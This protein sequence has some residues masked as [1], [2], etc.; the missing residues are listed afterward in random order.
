MREIK[1]RAWDKEAELF[2]IFTLADIR[3]LSE[4]DIIIGN[5]NGYTF[6][7]DAQTI[8]QFTGLADMN[9]KEI[10]EGDIVRLRNRSHWEEDS[11]HMQGIGQVVFIQEEV[12]WRAQR[13]NETTMML[14]WGGTETISVIGN[15]YENPELL[16]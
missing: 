15:I 7:L 9:G 12:C 6:R 10:Y 3:N 4:G 13:L 5:G 16:I 11:E 1:F 2:R 14:D 8:Q